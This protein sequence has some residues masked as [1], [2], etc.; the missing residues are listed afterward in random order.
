MINS[1]NILQTPPYLV[2]V[3]SL[4]S[5]HWIYLSYFWLG[6][7]HICLFILIFNIRSKYFIIDLSKYWYSLAIFTIYDI[8]D[9]DKTYIFIIS[10]HSYDFL[11]LHRILY[12]LSVFN[13]ILLSFLLF[14]RETRFCCSHW[15]LLIFDICIRYFN[16][17]NILS[18]KCL[19]L[20]EVLSSCGNCN[21]SWTF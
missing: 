5:Y 16:G 7:D 19:Q 3:L 18:I 15:W 10:A 21:G 11:R 8:F 12:C 1:R 17:A 6:E 13:R 4:M 2:A 9:I 14:S 20:S